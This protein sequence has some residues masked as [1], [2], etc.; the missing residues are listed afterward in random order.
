MHRLFFVLILLI[1]TDVSAVDVANL[2]QSHVPVATQGKKERLQ[3]APEALQQVL[4]KVVGDRAALDVV[5]VSSLLSQADT[6]IQQYQY[7]QVN[8]L[9]DD[10]TEPERLE[11]V[12][13][14][15]EVSLN[16]KLTSLA[17]PLWGKSRPEVLVWLAVDNGKSRTIVSNDDANKKIVKSLQLAVKLRGLPILM[18]VMDL[19]DQT[20]VQFADLWAGFS[21]PIERASDR[22]GSPV[23]LMASALID[24]NGAVKIR[25]QS[26]ING[27]T[28]KWQSRG[29]MHTAIQAGINELAD[30]LARRFSQLVS[31]NRD[32]S[33]LSLQI[34]HVRDYADYSRLVA[35]LTGLQYVSD[36]NVSNLSTDKLNITLSLKGDLT[37]FNQTLAIDRVLVSESYL[38]EDSFNYRL[39][40]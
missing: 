8:K 9:S 20:K 22:Y 38:A 5:D 14:F 2:Y 6:L 35:Y 28:E 4:L 18:P 7:Q 33:K 34:S 15:N 24:T 1:A 10:V 37:I 11:L 13:T 39:L 32:S 30:R 36:V 29:D 19:Q 12:L 26:L 23:I 27:K 17:L 31:N 16:Q 40:P 3:A 25:W 21:D